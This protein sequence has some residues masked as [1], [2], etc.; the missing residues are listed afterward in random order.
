M[1]RMARSQPV[2]IGER[3]RIFEWEGSQAVSLR[4]VN[5]P[6]AGQG[7]NDRAIAALLDHYGWP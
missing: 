3:A 1:H 2:K 7:G 6:A 4:S 5:R